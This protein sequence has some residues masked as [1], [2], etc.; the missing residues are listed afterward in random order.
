MGDADALSRPD[1]PRPGATWRDVAPPA[2]SRTGKVPSAV[3]QRLGDDGAAAE[4]KIVV[5]VHI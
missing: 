5:Y 2:G 4:M 3:S 1:T